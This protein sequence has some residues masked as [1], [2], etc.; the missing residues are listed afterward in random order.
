MLCREVYARGI[1]RGGI[2]GRS[3]VD[4]REVRAEERE[5]VEGGCEAV[6]GD[7]LA[8][9][10]GGEGGLRAALVCDGGGGGGGGEL[11]E[12]VWGERGG[13]Q[14]DCEGRRGVVFWEL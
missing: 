7:E 1:L 4:G 6:G 14:V 12:E 9:E 8:E 2:G 5:V 3:G 10:V 13:L 11:V